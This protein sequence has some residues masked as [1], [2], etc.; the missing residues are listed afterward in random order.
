MIQGK[1]FT[2]WDVKEIPV[3]DEYRWCNF[4]QRVPVVVGE[5]RR[6]VRLFPGDDTP[7]SFINCNLCNCEPPPGSKLINCLRVIKE[8]RL[9]SEADTITIDGHEIVLQHHIDRIHGYFNPETG[10]YDDLPT[11]QDV[12]VRR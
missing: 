2:N 5:K 1:N 12:E 10:G 11:P 6:G 4:T 9:D 7:R 8:F 3:D